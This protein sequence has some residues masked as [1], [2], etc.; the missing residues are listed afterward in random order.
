MS[1]LQIV[2]PREV[3]LTTRTEVSVFRTVPSPHLRRIGAWIFVDHFGPT[4]QVTGMTVAQHPHTGLQTVTWLFEGA[5][6]H[7]DSIGSVQNVLPGQLNLMTAGSGVAHSERSLAAGSAR[8]HAV[9][10]WLALPEERRNGAPDF[11][12]LETAEAAISGDAAFKVIIGEYL[13]VKSD[14]RV[15]HPTLGA[16]LRLN[17]EHRL[18][19]RPDWEYGLLLVA[20]SLTIDGQEVPLRHLVH[21]PL[22]SQSPL[23]VGNDAV[24]ILLGGAPF[25]EQIVMWWNFVA[26]SHEEIVEMRNHWNQ[27]DYP[28]FTDE[29]GGWIPAPELP[30]VQLRSR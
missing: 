18:Q 4:E 5:V 1:S 14:A 25:Q 13:G 15:Y 9:Q 21:L 29:L 12:H 11:Q 24:G 30:N 7:R 19:L 8:M 17:G 6:D 23:L 22:G 16:E 20:G 3:K 2:A 10:L 26:R 28:E 27:R